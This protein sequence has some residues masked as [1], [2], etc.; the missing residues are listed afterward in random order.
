[1][2]NQQFQSWLIAE[3]AT[4]EWFLIQ[5]Q[6]RPFASISVPLILRLTALWVKAPGIAYSEFTMR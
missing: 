6:R 1:M 5:K 4:R 2:E 3:D